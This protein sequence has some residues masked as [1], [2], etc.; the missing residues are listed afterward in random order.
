MNTSIPHT[1]EG[2]V[3]VITMS[4]PPANT[5]T[6]VSLDA[7]AELI[8][9]FNADK[10]IYSLVITG[11]GDKF[12][13][14]GADLKLFADGDPITAGN[15]AQFFGEAFEALADFRGVSIAAINGFAM[16]GGLEA[17]L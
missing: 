4:N 9:T 16:G 7:L 10:N 13:S 5:W 14:A 8:Q 1:I 17:A 3:A 6:R 11:E 2:H 15:M 12:F